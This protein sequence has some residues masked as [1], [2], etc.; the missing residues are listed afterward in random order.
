M[1]DTLKIMKIALQFVLIMICGCVSKTETDT[2]VNRLVTDAL[3]QQS[4]TPEEYRL[5]QLNQRLPSAITDRARA[6]CLAHPNTDPKLLAN[7]KNGLIIT[8]MD[9]EQVRVIMGQPWHAET[10]GGVGGSFDQWTFLDSTLEADIFLYFSDGRL[11][12]WQNLK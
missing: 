4:K 12:R 8:G 2:Q 5:E 6:Y 11:V 10:S 1:R 9:Q 7:F 3:K